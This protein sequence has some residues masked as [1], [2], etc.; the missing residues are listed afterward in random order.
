VK[1]R[2]PQIDADCVDFHG[3]P[4]LLT[5]YSPRRG[6][7]LRTIPISF[8]YRPLPAWE[9]AKDLEAV[10]RIRLDRT[11]QTLPKSSRQSSR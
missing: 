11:H 1:N 3:P 7:K 9:E 4:P 10:S 2:L 8:A 6:K 5:S